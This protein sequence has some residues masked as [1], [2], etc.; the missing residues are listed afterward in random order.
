MAPTVAAAAESSSDLWSQQ[1]VNTAGYIGAIA[2]GLHIAVYS[3]ATY[4][5][6]TSK[7]RLRRW[8]QQFLNTFIFALGTIRF[9]TVIRFDQEAWVLHPDYPGGPSAYLKH[10]RSTPVAVFGLSCGSLANFTLVGLMLWRTYVVWDTWIVLILPS[11]LYISAI[12]F[13][14]ADIAHDVH[15]L[16]GNWGPNL[17][18]AC[19]SITAANI[20]LLTALISLRILYQ[21]RQMKKSGVSMTGGDLMNVVSM[22][23]ESM[24]P[25]AVI[26]LVFIVLYARQDATESLLLPAIVQVVCISQHLV[27]IQVYRGRVW[28][29]SAPGS[30]VH[31]EHSSESSEISHQNSSSSS[32][33][34]ESDDTLGTPDGSCFVNITYG[35]SPGRNEAAEKVN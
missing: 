26:F 21:R 5:I 25:A 16:P 32:V 3:M 23:I 33:R 31:F 10:V 11:I 7:R 20:I 30:S 4:F 34:F 18:I 15:P 17:G 9:A 8:R 28:S 13:T 6:L 35:S 27:L 29:T 1:A 19:W 14:C 12:V 22:L 2:Y 24:A